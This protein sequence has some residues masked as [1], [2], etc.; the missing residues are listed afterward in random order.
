[1]TTIHRTSTP[2]D[3]SLMTQHCS[4]MGADRSRRVAGH[5]LHA[6]ARRL[7]VKASW[8]VTALLAVSWLS[9]CQNEDA[10]K[11][12]LGAL[13]RVSSVSSAG[14]DTLLSG[15]TG[16]AGELFQGELAESRS[17]WALYG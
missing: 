6:G 14:W 9:A 1:M 12:D 2:H 7:V 8:I 10:A 17:F 11:R 13:S 15:Q 5:A 16:K 3:G 4:P